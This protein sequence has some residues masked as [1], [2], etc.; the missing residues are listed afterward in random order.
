MDLV[1]YDCVMYFEISRDIF[2]IFLIDFSEG[3]K[4]VLF[5]GS[6]IIWKAR[7]GPPLLDTYLLERARTTRATDPSPNPFVF[8]NYFAQGITNH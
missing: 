7:G 1:D 3:G 4:A 2:H 8:Q 5:V 6:W